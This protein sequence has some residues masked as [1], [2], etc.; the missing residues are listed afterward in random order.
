MRVASTRTIYYIKLICCNSVTGGTN[1]RGCNV[2]SIIQNYGPVVRTKTK[3]MT[4]IRNLSPLHEM[5]SRCQSNN[6]DNCRYSTMLLLKYAATQPFAKN[7]S[8]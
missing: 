1:A 4:T 6:K 8:H 3:N 2:T 7:L 5:F